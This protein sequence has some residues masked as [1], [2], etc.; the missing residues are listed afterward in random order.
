[1]WYFHLLLGLIPKPAAT[2]SAPE[3]NWGAV[4][5]RGSAVVG[6]A[7]L[8]IFLG[9]NPAF[10]PEKLP[11][12]ET[13]SAYGKEIPIVKLFFYEGEKA[14]KAEKDVRSLANVGPG[15]DVKTSLPRI[16]EALPTG[17][18]VVNIQDYKG[19]AAKWA[20]MVILDNSQTMVGQTELWSPDR[21]AAAR[22]AFAGLVR[23]MPQGSKIAIRDFFDEVSGRKKGRELR[24]R[25]SRVLSDWTD[26]PS[27]ELGMNLDQTGP[28]AENNLCMAAVRSL[29]TDF[30]ALESFSPRLVLITDGRTE[31]SLKEILQA[32]EGSKFK[33]Q[34]R[35]DV[36]AVGMKPLMQEAYTS[37][38]KAT[39][40]QLLNVNQPADLQPALTDYLALLQTPRPELI[41]IVGHGANYKILPGEEAKVSPGAY[42]ITLPEMRG[43][44]PSKRTVKDVKIASGGKTIL[45]VR[46][47]EGQL[48]V[49]VNRH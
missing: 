7:V 38:A 44:D 46:I 33:N 21:M 2:V 8:G 16:D 11:S 4:L 25:V 48:V 20:I 12:K 29:K 41:Q 17:T 26:T 31:C 43:L 24:L 22:D 27:K 45:G 3:G 15:V 47:Q 30:E 35:V 18:L 49:G 28:G 10:A 42:T 40:G 32:V 19:V 14:A 23:G 39:G 37:L 5:V 34:V 6:A 1:M 13:I 9:T 36:I